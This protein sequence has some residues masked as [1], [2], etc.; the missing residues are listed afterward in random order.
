MDPR[1][2]VL[3]VW[4]RCGVHK[5]RRPVILVDQAGETIPPSDD[6]TRPTVR[7]RLD[8]LIRNAEI[9]A[10]MRPGVVVMMNIA[11]KHGFEMSAPRRSAASRGTPL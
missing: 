8:R 1:S 6:A 10:T 9:E 4:M 7:G 3:R 2:R 5:S 11:A